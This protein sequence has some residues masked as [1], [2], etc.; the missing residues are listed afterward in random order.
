MI[1]QINLTRNTSQCQGRLRNSECHLFT[2]ECYCPDSRPIVHEDECL[3]MVVIGEICQDDLQ[4]LHFDNH[5]SC[6]EN[7]CDCQDS[8]ILTG[9]QCVEARKVEPPQQDFVSFSYFVLFIPCS[10]L[11]VLII[12]GTRL[13]IVLIKD[14]KLKSL[15]ER[16][17]DDHTERSKFREDVLGDTE[18]IIDFTEV[19]ENMNDNLMADKLEMLE[20]YHEEFKIHKTI[21]KSQAGSYFEEYLV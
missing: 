6:S 5:S 10:V 14:Q 4:C 13:I 9:N 11:L 3:P 20:S 21:R 12:L 15:K 1:L 16:V 17:Q 2:G 7:V 18:E 19:T 8:F